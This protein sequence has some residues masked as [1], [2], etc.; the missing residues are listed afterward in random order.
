MLCSAGLNP[1]EYSNAKR[2]FNLQYANE[3]FALQEISK[4]CEI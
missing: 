1:L 3:E 2:G 4:S